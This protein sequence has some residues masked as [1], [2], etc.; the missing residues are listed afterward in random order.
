[1]SRDAYPFER[2]ARA[3][4]EQ[5]DVAGAAPRGAR[6]PPRRLGSDPARYG[7]RPAPVVADELARRRE[8]RRRTA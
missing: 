4:L 7:L 2:R 8:S 5:A 3:Q 1:M 6:R